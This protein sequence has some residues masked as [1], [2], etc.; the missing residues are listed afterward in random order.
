MMSVMTDDEI[1]PSFARIRILLTQTNDDDDDVG[2]DN[3]SNDSN[4]YYFC[5]YLIGYYYSL[6]SLLFLKHEIVH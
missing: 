5:V 6:F 4:V 2:D 3:G 1:L